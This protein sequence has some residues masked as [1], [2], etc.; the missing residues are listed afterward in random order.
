MKRWK[1]VWSVLCLWGSGRNRE[2]M[3][4]CMHIWV[5]PYLDSSVRKIMKMS[6]SCGCWMWKPHK[7]QRSDSSALEN[8]D[9]IKAACCGKEISVYVKTINIMFIIKR[10]NFNQVLMSF[11]GVATYKD[12]GGLKTMKWLLCF[13]DCTHLSFVSIVA[14]TEELKLKMPWSRALSHD[15][16]IN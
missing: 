3:H 9:R 8:T 5:C 12:K 15:L 6:P 4:S 13:P 7:N 11:D 2:D 14:R 1:I 16:W 10:N